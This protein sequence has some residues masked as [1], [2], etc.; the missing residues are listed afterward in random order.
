MPAGDV[1]VFVTVRDRAQTVS[2]HTHTT[3]EIM[4]Y[5]RICWVM[6]RS[7]LLLHYKETEFKDQS[8]LG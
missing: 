4:I 6:V 1:P 5:A 2:P 7:P 8:Q 3:Q